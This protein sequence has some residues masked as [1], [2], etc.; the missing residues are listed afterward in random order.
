MGDLYRLYGREKNST[1]TLEQPINREQ[2]L[3]GNLV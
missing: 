1:K 3:K 2:M